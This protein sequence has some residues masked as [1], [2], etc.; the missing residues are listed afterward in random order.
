MKILISTQ[1]KNNDQDTEDTHNSEESMDDLPKSD[2]PSE[3]VQNDEEDLEPSDSTKLLIGDDTTLLTPDWEK[4]KFQMMMNRMGKVCV[5]MSGILI[6]ANMVA[7]FTVWRLDG[8]EIA[9]INGYGF[10]LCMFVIGLAIQSVYGTS[11]IQDFGDF[12]IDLKV[13]IFRYQI[14]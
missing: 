1:D 12:G 9:I 10:A 14:I 3:E 13:C 5:F 7:T 8:Q 2:V 6:L 11:K 4:E